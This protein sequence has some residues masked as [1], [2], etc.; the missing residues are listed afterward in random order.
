M[1][2]AML[3]VSLLTKI[4]AIVGLLGTEWPERHL[5]WSVLAGFSI[6][7]V[8]AFAHPS[9]F[10]MFMNVAIPVVALS[11]ARADP[12]RLIAKSRLLVAATL[13]VLLCHVVFIS[14]M[15]TTRF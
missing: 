8:I 4:A 15:A 14:Y 1:L 6:P 2:A 12:E 9:Y 11:A 5:I 13:V 10:Q 7:H 3:V